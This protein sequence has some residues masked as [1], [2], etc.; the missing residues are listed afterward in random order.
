MSESTRLSY[1]QLFIP[2]FKKFLI[3]CKDENIDTDSVSTNLD[4]LENTIKNLPSVVS[5]GGVI[6]PAFLS[7]NQKI[8]NLVLVPS[9]K[10]NLQNLAIAVSSN[11]CICLQG[12][13]GCGKTALIEYLAGV[14]GHDSSN[15]VKVQLGDQTDSK[16]LL[17]MYRCTDMPG[18][19]IWQPGVLTQA[20]V[21]GKW[22]L[23]EDIDNAVLDVASVLSNLMET[24]TLCVPGYRDTIYAH[25]GFRL[26]VTQRL[27]TSTT[28][29]RKHITI[30][31][32]LLQKHWL[33]VDMESL[34]KDE[35]ITVV[36]TLFPVLNS[37][38][39]RMVDIFLQFST[40]NSDRD[41]NTKIG[42]QISTRDL[43]KWCSRVIVNF[44]IS[45]GTCT[46]G[47]FQNAM[48]IFC[49]SVPDRSTFS[50]FL[51]KYFALIVRISVV[52]L[53]INFQIN[54]FFLIIACLKC[55]VLMAFFYRETS[56]ADENSSFRIQYH[57]R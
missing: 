49:C 25:S 45:S 3:D 55:F 54:L 37:V 21:T 44:N 57:R 1:A 18:E 9:T 26:F 41:N 38:A 20:V 24:G 17:G 19:F 4:L 2:N 14:T 53:F 13:V 43:I 27:T 15:F 52:I 29:T 33:C 6:L 36:R 50:F 46:L 42:R 56:T 31:S 47:I 35:L 40:G 7:K 28:G 5:V 30:S 34:S 16:M 23:L 10:K 12:P 48:D 22:L 39:T 11:K 32:S 8:C 51:F